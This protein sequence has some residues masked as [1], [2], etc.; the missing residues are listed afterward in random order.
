MLKRISENWNLSSSPFVLLLLLLF[1]LYLTQFFFNLLST[2]CRQRAQLSCI[3]L[4]HTFTLTVCTFV[5]FRSVSFLFLAWF[6]SYSIGKLFAI[7]YTFESRRWL[8][9]LLLLYM[10]VCVFVRFTFAVP[11]SHV[12]FCADTLITHYNILFCWVFGVFFCYIFSILLCF[13]LFRFM[14]ELSLSTVFNSYV[15]VTCHLMLVL[16]FVFSLLLS[17][18]LSRLKLFDG[19]YGELQIK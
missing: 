12:I 3:C 1:V 19:F 4:S 16:L 8:L 15:F 18:P 14:Y 11:D 13:V 5:S 17:I 9:L 2:I 10:C 7:Q 6:G